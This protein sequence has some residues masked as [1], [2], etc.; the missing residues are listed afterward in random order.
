MAERVKTRRHELGM[1]QSEAAAASAGGIS[2]A[3]W[4][5]LERAVRDAYRPSTMAAACRVLGWRVDSID[6]I[7]DGKEQ[8]V[9]DVPSVPI[10][11][12]NDPLLDK[13]DKLY[14]L[15]A[16]KTL[17]SRRADDGETPT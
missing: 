2:L 13:D 6:R 5:N 17:I 1:T 15:G 10:A 3:T 12:E 8:I 4:N 11:I 16:Y 9:A 7:L 14:L